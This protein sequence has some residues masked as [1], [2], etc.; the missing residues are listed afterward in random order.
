MT[1]IFTD[2][3]TISRLGIVIALLIGIMMTSPSRAEVYYPDV[4]I[5]AEDRNGLSLRYVPVLSEDFTALRRADKIAAGETAFWGRSLLVAVPEGAEINYSVSYS[6]LGSAA[7]PVEHDFLPNDQPLVRYDGLTTARNHRIARFSVFPQR[8]ENGRLAAYTDFVIDISFS[9]GTISNTVATANRI[10]SVLALTIVNPGQFYEF[11]A[12]QERNA[13]AKPKS[14]G[15]NA[16]ADWYKIQVS[17]SGV[18]AISGSLLIQAGI[19]LNNLPIDSLR[20]FYAGGRNPSF[21]PSDPAPVLNEIPMMIEDD[22][23][24]FFDSGDRILFYAEGPNRFDFQGGTPQYIKNHYYSLNCYWLAVGGDY[25]SAPLRMA[26]GNYVP[27]GPSDH[28]LTTARSFVRLETDNSLRSDASN[29]IWDY[30]TW[31]WNDDRDQTV[32]ANL[33]GAVNGDSIDITLSTYGNSSTSVLQING[34]SMVRYF[35]VGKYHWYGFGAI[36]GLNQIQLSLRPAGEIWLDYVDISYPVALKT[37]TDQFDFSSY[38]YGG[39]IVYRLADLASGDAILDITDTDNPVRVDVFSLNGDTAI[40]QKSTGSVP[41]RFV[42][43]SDASIFTPVAVTSADIIDLRADLDQYD[44]LVVAPRAFDDAVAEYSAYR[45][46]NGGHA[47]KFAAV[48]DIYNCFGYGLESPMAIRDYARFAFENYQAPAPFALL[49]MG[50]GH[51]DY[52][53]NLDL[54]TPMYVPPYVW[55]RLNTSSDDYYVYFGK[56]DSLDSDGSFVTPG[57]RG[58]D[59]MVARWPIR[60]SGE[61]RDYLDKILEYES[62]TTEGAWRGRITYVADDEFKSTISTEII[63]TAQAE[64]LAV[65]HTPS[66]F[67][68]NKIYLTEYPFASSGDKPRVND[69]IVDALNTGSLII[70]YIG[71]GSPDVWADEHVFRKTS[72]LPRLQ[73]RDRLTTVIAASCSIGFFDAP[74]K[75]G[76]AEVLFRQE[77]GMIASVSATRL[78]YATDN[79][80]FNYDIYDAIF[81]G[82]TNLCEA[83]FAT[84]MLHQSG[85]NTSLIRNDRAYAVFGDPLGRIGLP[86]YRIEIDSISDSALVPLAPF[87]FSGRITDST[88]ATQPLDGSIDVLVYDSEIQRE[89]ELG[90][91]YSLGGPTLYRGPVAVTNGQF[92]GQFI[93]PLDIDYGGAAAK[94]TGYGIFGSGAA[95]GARDSLQISSTVAQT[96]DNAGPTIEYHFA[97]VPDFVPG[98]RVPEN[99]TLVISLEDAS[100][101][102]L[103]GGLGHRIELI[104][105]NDNNAAINLTDRFAY[106]AGSYQAGE[107]RFTLPEL[108]PERHTFMLRAWDNAN[109]P[110]TTEFDATTTMRG[111]IAITQAL[112]YP[113]PMEESTDFYIELSE[114]AEAVDLQI[115]TLSGRKIV[116]VTLN[117]IAAGRNR[118]YTWS[119]RDMDGDRLAQGVYM[120]KVIARGRMSSGADDENTAEAFGKL[121]LLN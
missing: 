64:T 48:E 83:A 106:T 61:I 23:N 17:Q 47:V 27:S 103:T 57:D 35:G 26:S 4:D 49:L 73:N 63:H 11:A 20:M 56:I 41:S 87:A 117:N 55:D 84:K 96:S 81:G 86:S 60:S 43:Y 45:Q 99:A 62:L 91:S 94:I 30:F 78:V 14:S 46:Q 68:L 119:G 6:R 58:W 52:L 101:I 85:S 116:D 9:G 115:F 2:K 105:D 111:S 110:A 24:G 12:Q 104:I 37:R 19:V 92:S 120:Y 69:A 95:I 108:S 97:E 54:Q 40:F 32:L 98:S 31:Y 107:V 50:D 74:D 109:N 13:F 112:N 72:D 80:I 3:N 28:V 5:I 67:I 71:H 10:D 118:L 59:M 79:A 7:V 102:N 82:K 65:M 33:P 29:R 93:V 1:E 88:G 76:M 39:V 113:N 100:G 16:A 70:N 51:Y 121:V 77:G 18:T 42:A 53:N 75:E 8:V 66:E 15:F 89:H 25:V 34:A 22:G 36:D 90:I 44:C 21:D 38:G 114:T